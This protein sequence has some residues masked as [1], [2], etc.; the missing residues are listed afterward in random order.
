MKILI[1]IKK[2]PEQRFLVNIV[3]KKRIKEIH[4]LISRGSRSK[5]IAITLAEGT[6]I[7]E[8]GEQELIHTNAELILTEEYISRDLISVRRIGGLRQC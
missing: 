7:K 5:A 8:V 3:D 6:F 1:K 4:R 2:S